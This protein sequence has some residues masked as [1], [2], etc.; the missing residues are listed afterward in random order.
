MFID[1]KIHITILSTIKN[2]FWKSV[3]EA[4]V[5]W[6]KALK[7]STKIPIEYTPIWGNALFNVPFN[8]TMFN[9]NMIFLPDFFKEDGTMISQK[10][11]EERLG[12]KIP[13][14]QYFGLRKA[15]PKEW[16]EFMRIY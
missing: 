15:I 6:Y 8:S 16:R 9:N 14:T 10:N 1:S 5:S 4:Y 2:K 13:F 12:V 3:A 7:K 11:L